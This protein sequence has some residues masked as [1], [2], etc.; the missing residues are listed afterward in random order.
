MKR[1]FVTTCESGT[2]RYFKYPHLRFSSSKP[3]SCISELS[4][5]VVE[6]AKEISVDF[7]VTFTKI[8]YFTM[9]IIFVIC[10]VLPVAAAYV[11]N[12]SPAVS[13]KSLAGIPAG[14]ILHYFI[15]NRVFKALQQLVGNVGAH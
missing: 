10:I 15:R 5:D 12:G 4:L 9:I 6:N 14:F 13:L 1:C 7:G 11:R 2:I 3:L 8:R